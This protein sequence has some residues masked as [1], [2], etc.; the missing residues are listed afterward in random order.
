VVKIVW[1]ATDYCIKATALDAKK[2]GFET[3][4]VLKKWIAGVAP[5]TTQKAFEEMISAGIQIID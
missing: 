3:V 5:D 2:L 1:L 4:Q